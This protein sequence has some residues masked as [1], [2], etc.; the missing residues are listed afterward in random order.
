MVYMGGLTFDS[1]D[2]SESLTIPNRVAAK[3][4][5]HAMISRR[6]LYGTIFSAVN[7]LS[8]TGDLK[9]VLACYRS[10]MEERDVAAQSF[11][12]TEENHRDIL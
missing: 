5:G 7:F 4:F 6:G 1:Q 3:R 12:K 9:Q 2:P 8:S 11:R 10:L